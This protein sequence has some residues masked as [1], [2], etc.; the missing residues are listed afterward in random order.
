V[1]SYERNRALGIP[2]DD[3]VGDPDQRAADA[4]LI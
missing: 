1:D 2:F 3:L 4:V